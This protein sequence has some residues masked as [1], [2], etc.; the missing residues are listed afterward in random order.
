MSWLAEVAAAEEIGGLGMA[1]GC[2]FVMPSIAGEALNVFGT[3][4]QTAKH[5]KASWPP[6]IERFRGQEAFL[7]S[8]IVCLNGCGP[9]LRMSPTGYFTMAPKVGR[10]IRPNTWLLTMAATR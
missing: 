10:T 5:L 6:I 9:L 4:E 8:G 2:V 3:R 7:T 1:L